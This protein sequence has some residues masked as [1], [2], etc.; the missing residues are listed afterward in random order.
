MSACTNGKFWLGTGRVVV[1][2][3][4]L[5]LVAIDICQVARFNAK[6]LREQ[7]EQSVSQILHLL[8]VF[9]QCIAVNKQKRT[10]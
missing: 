10:R 6:S 9:K 7:L 8:G 1:A 4:D 5:S 3:Y 2:E